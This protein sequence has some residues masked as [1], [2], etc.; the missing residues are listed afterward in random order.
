MKLGKKLRKSVPSSSRVA[1][2]TLMCS[3]NSLTKLIEVKVGVRKE[4]VR[5][6]LSLP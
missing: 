2:L 4:K 3:V 1:D 5:K 6:I